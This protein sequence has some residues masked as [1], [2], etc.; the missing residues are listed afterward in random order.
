MIP[1]CLLL[2][3]LLTSTAKPLTAKTKT[4]NNLLYSLLIMQDYCVILYVCNLQAFGG[5]T[6]QSSATKYSTSIPILFHSCDPQLNFDVVRSWKR[7]EKENNRI[8]R[9]VFSEEYILEILKTGVL[10]D[11]NK[12][13]YAMLFFTRTP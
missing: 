3:L 13:R 5:N 11:L 4:F 8:P 1:P 10:P 12:F 2:S 7:N 9:D 6:Y